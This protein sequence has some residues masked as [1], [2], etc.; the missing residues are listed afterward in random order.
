VL[1]EAML[2]SPANWKG[3]YHGSAEEQRLLRT[4]SYSDRIRYYWAVPAAHH[5]VDKLIANLTARAIPE[6]LL[7]AYLPAQYAAVREGKLR[8]EPLELVIHASQG[9]LKAYAQ[10]CYGA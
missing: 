8:T 1:E 10:A 4:F 6:T 5:A 7:S 3:H 9:A 2:E